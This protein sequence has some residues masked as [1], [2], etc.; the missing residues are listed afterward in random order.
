MDGYDSSSGD[1]HA[2]R[3]LEVH[4]LTIHDVLRVE[5]PSMLAW[6][7][8]EYHGGI[9][10]RPLHVMQRRCGADILFTLYTL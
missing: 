7:S 10:T 9:S 6:T 1:E 4:R 8:V 2:I 5:T 3:V